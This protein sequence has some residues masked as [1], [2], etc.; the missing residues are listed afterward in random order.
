MEFADKRKMFVELR[1]SHL[2]SRGRGIQPT[3]LFAVYSDL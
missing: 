2:L 1:S 3:T